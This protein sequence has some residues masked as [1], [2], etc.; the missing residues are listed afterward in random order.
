MKSALSFTSS[1]KWLAQGVGLAGMYLAFAW[2]G[3]AAASAQGSVPAVWPASGLAIAAVWWG[4]YRLAPAIG[5]G[6]FI[7]TRLNGV[8]VLAS[9]GVAF[10]DMIEP[11]IR[12]P[13]SVDTP[14]TGMGLAIVKQS[15]AR[16]SGSVGAESTPGK[17]SCFRLELPTA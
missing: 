6:A 2:L 15:V 13:G 8:F 5:L 11:V 4:G 7:F 17:G 16:M 9:A 14:G 10:A 12:L 1:W 3:S